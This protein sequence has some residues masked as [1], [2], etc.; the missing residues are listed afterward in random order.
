MIKFAEN[1]SFSSKELDIR[2]VCKAAICYSGPISD[3]YLE[4]EGLVR[5]CADRRTNG[6]G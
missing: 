3:R 5:V 4:N 1:C 2:S 6:Y